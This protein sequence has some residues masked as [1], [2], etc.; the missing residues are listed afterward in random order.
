MSLR[1]IG[2]SW[3][4]D[5]YTNGK[6][7]RKKLS[8]NKATA[9][10]IYDTI[11]R[12][13]DLSK[14]G[15]CDKGYD[16]KKM[17]QQFLSEISIRLSNKTL[18]YYN[19]ILDEVTEHLACTP[20]HEARNTF[21]DYINRKQELGLS[22]RTLKLIIE[23]TKRMFHHAVE[24]NV[25]SVNP[26]SG[27]KNPQGT[28]KIRRALEPG[29]IKSLLKNSGR[30]KIIWLTFLNTGLRRSELVELKWK[31]IDLKKGTLTIEKER[32]GKGVGVIPLSGEIKKEL[33]LMKVGDRESYVFTTK[34]GTPYRNNLLRVFRSCV[35]KAGI[36]QDGISIHSLRYTFATT[37]ASKN[38]HPRYIQ[39]L[40]RHKHIS[41]SMDI[42][43]DVYKE[44]LIN[45]VKDLKFT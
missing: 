43:T 34:N 40:M 23:L 12:D 29:E 41:T 6:R 37:L 14:F 20:L 16:L 2:N 28:K 19:V 9:Q 42:Y 44:D 30:Y 25:I 38:K 35:K 18:S 4:A 39:A 8:S 5:F 10:K 31:D 13:R 22:A 3:F 36:N 17:Q 21:S 7:V 27:I 33:A 45:V 15:L 32:P 24:T 26:L 1:K 11:I